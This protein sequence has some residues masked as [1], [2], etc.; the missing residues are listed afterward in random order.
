MEGQITGGLE[1]MKNN[2]RWVLANGKY[3]EQPVNYHIVDD[4]ESPTKVRVYEPFCPEH[5][6]RFKAQE[7][8]EDLDE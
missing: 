5:L 1:D 2:C 4:G 8:Q 7:A 6:V 3:C